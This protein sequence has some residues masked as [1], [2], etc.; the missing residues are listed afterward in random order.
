M[1]NES[2]M[3]MDAYLLAVRMMNHETFSLGMPPL[4]SKASN[5]SSIES[6]SS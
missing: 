2:K 1:K 4:D 6:L 5:P 3:C